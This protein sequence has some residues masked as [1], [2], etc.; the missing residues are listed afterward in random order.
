M[1]FAALTLSGEVTGVANLVLVVFFKGL[2]TTVTTA[3]EQPGLPRRFRDSLDSFAG[4]LEVGKETEV[5]VLHCN[6]P[7]GS[8]H[9]VSSP[10][11]P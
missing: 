8:S 10:D 9:L 6:H 5:A 1:P 11:T 4:G 3:D 2:V 7:K